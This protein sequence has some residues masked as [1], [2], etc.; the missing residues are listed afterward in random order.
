MQ[1]LDGPRSK[2]NTRTIGY[3]KH[4]TAAAAAQ[5]TTDNTKV[6]SC[7]AKTKSQLHT[8]GASGYI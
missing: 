3:Q 1:D 6:P 5:A 7:R 4:T 2:T 8:A